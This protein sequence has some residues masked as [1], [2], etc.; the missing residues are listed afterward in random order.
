MRSTNWWTKQTDWIKDNMYTILTLIT[1]DY[2]VLPQ[3][4]QKNIQVNS[5]TSISGS[6]VYYFLLATP[7]IVTYKTYSPGIFR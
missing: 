1:G 4:Q 5:L 2:T 6:V 3:N 7:W